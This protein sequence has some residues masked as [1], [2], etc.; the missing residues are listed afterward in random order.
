MECSFCISQRPPEGNR[1]GTPSSQCC[2]RNPRGLAVGQLHL[3]DRVQSK[4]SHDWF[5]HYFHSGALPR[6]LLESV[7]TGPHR[8]MFPGVLGKPNQ[9]CSV[10]IL[11]SL[12]SPPS[13][14][15]PSSVSPLRLPCSH[16]FPDCGLDMPTTHH[17]LTI[18]S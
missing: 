12:C 1:V 7:S 13:G 3:K 9:R 2:S 10:S 6:D 5:T 11:H 8:V 14:H 17:C 4:S 15:P 16:P 18:S